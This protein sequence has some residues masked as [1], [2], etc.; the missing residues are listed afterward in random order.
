[1]IEKKKKKKKEDTYTYWVNCSTSE[2]SKFKPDSLNVSKLS[3]WPLSRNNKHSL[4]TSEPPVR[5][6]SR[7]LMRLEFNED[8]NLVT[9]S[10]SKALWL[11]SNDSMYSTNLN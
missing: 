4:N 8:R 11:T 2:S 6:T 9:P 7:S 10:L 3:K 5:D 1:M